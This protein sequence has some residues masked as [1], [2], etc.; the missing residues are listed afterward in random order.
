VAA[1]AEGIVVEARAVAGARAAVA[2]VVLVAAVEIAEI[3]RTA[4]SH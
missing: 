1:A 2:I 4:V 3:A